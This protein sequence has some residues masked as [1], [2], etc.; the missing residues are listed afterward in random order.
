MNQEIHVEMVCHASFRLWL[1]DGTFTVDPWY[2]GAIACNSTFHFPPLRHSIEEVAKYTRALYISHIHPDHFSP[3]TL[4]HFDRGTP[5]YIGEYRL[6][7]FRDGIRALGFRVHEIPFQ[8]KVRIEELDVAIAILESDYE[9]SAAY[10]SAIVIDTGDFTVFNN[11]DCFLRD[12]KIEWVRRNFSVDYGFIGFSPASFYY[13]ASFEFEPEVRDRLLHEAAER[14]YADFVR[15]ASGVRPRIAI[16][17]AS[18]ARLLHRDLLWKNACFNSAVEA[19]HRLQGTGLR[20]EVLGPGDCILADGQVRRVAPVLDRD[21]EARAI[22]E[23]AKGRANELDD[24]WQDEAPARGD[25]VAQFRDYVLDLWARHRDALPGVAD[26]VIA[27]RLTGPGGGSFYFDFS[28]P[29]SEIFQAGEPGAYDMRYTY[30]ANLLQMRLDGAIDWD[31]LHYSNRI[32]IDQKRFAREVYAMLRSETNPVD[33]VH[34]AGGL[35]AGAG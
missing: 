9:E 21:Q 22:A 16:P 4:A 2:K 35:R 1:A 13:P 31:E 27:Y 14:R 34:F 8:E 12:H 17:F 6:K 24:L 15:V 19:V 29:G 32:S 26:S 30:P 33:K 28:R 3:A 23:Y 25:V 7:Q 20:G 18:G 5:V 10:D 11:N